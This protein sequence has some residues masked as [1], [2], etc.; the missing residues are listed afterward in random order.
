MRQ[1]RTPTRPIP[2]R[3]SCCRSDIL[4]ARALEQ[5]VYDLAEKV[6]VALLG[7]NDEAQAALQPAMTF[8]REEQQAGAAGTNFRQDFAYALYVSA[9]A[10]TND[11]DGHAKRIADLTDAVRLIDGSS[12]EAKQLASTRELSGL[13]TAARAK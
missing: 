10:R 1:Q 5:Q 8:Y 2:N 9:H 7:G 3:A 13:I 4:R 11:A 6:L 12:A